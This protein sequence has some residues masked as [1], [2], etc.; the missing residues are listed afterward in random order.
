MSITISH[1]SALFVTRLLRANGEGLRN[2]DH[3]AIVRPSPWTGNRWTMRE[4]TSNE[5]KWHLPSARQPL[6]VIVRR[7]TE[8]IRMKNICSHLCSCNLPANSILWLDEHTSMSG[9]ALLFVQMA[10]S[11]S[12]PELVL[13]GC[14]LC[15]NFTK[16]AYDPA[17]KPIV[18]FIQ[19]AISA[20]ELRDYVWSLDFIPGVT[21]A[22]KAVDYVSDHALSVP[23]AILATI[24][25]LPP[26][27]C[28]YGM[29]PVVLN[30]RVDLANNT[31]IQSARARYP[32]LMFAFAPV[33]I[34]YDGESHLDLVGLVRV[35]QAAALQ[36]NSTAPTT[37][38]LINKLG[39]VRAKVVDDTRRNRQLASQGKIV[40]PVTK[41]DLNEYNGLDA[42]THDILSCAS[43]V[44]KTDVSE[45]TS[46]LNDTEKSR[47]RNALLLSM[48]TSGGVEG[49]RTP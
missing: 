21:A 28:G 13:L 20:V 36:N 34:N 39:D 3:C 18:D 15:G 4:F 25:S 41:E 7:P 33:G 31:L 11:L 22:R 19:P 29:G 47:E 45:F 32:D 14:E 5:W 46:I 2:M 9:P 8:R 44:F 48:L 6:H 24:Y 38:E 42:L 17:R 40:F 37:T 30:H 35:A 49:F 12:F 1:E 16:S 43:K 27:E 10:E 23:E 26:E